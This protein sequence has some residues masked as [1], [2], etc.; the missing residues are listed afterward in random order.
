MSGAARCVLSDAGVI[1]RRAFRLEGGVADRAGAAGLELGE[2]ERDA[3]VLVHAVEAVAGDGRTRHL[4]A[5]RALVDA[6]LAPFARAAMS[7]T[8]PS[9]CST[10]WRASPRR[11]SLRSITTSSPV[12]VKS[13][14]PPTLR[15]P[16]RRSSSVVV[17]AVGSYDASGTTKVQIASGSASG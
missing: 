12:S 3:H 7:S 1:R 5:G 9:A 4:E 6:H 16:S 15:A 17:S 8:R 11:S 13:T 14:S 2:V 10:A